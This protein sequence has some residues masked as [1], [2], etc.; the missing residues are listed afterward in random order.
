MVTRSRK[1]RSCSP[2]AHTDER[3]H[4]H[5]GRLRI[6]SVQYRAAVEL[7]KRVTPQK[8]RGNTQA[9]EALF[10]R[11]LQ[12]RS[13]KT[14][15][16]KR[17]AG[18][19]GR[20]KRNLKAAGGENGDPNKKGGSGAQQQAAGQAGSRAGGVEQKRK[21]GEAGSRAGGVEQKRKVGQAS[22]V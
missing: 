6:L 4:Y 19:V 13:A 14:S 5:H 10:A 12:Q 7:P 8:L 15:V 16:A 11:Y 22:G 1:R 9:Y 3:A 18:E 2:H 17:Q 21:A 20:R